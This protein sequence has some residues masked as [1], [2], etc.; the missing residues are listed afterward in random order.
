MRNMPLVVLL[1]F[2]ACV[3]TTESSTEYT[4]SSSTKTINIGG[5]TTE[6]GGLARIQVLT[7]LGVGSRAPGATWSTLATFTASTSGV[8][9]GGQSYYSWNGNVSGFS[10]A[11]WPSAGVARVRAQYR[12]GGT[13]TDGNTFDDL[14]C[15]TEH[16]G[17]DFASI[18]SA[19]ASHDSGH[20]HFVDGDPLTSSSRSYISLRETPTVSFGGA[21]VNDPALDYYAKVDPAS[22]RTTLADW[23]LLNGFDTFGGTLPGYDPVVA[24]TYFNKADLELGR[25]MFCLKRTGNAALACYVTNY[26]DPALFPNAGPQ[27]D[28]TAAL[29][30]A[31]GQTFNGLVAT[32]AM[33]YRPNDAANR[34]TFFAFD[35]AG[36]RV[37]KVKLDSQGAKNMPGACLSCHGGA[38]N[39]GTDSVVGAHFL[40]FDVDNF[41]YSTAAG[42]TLSSQQGAFRALN[43]LILGAGPTAAITELVTGWYGGN[44][45]ATGPAQDTEFMPAAWVDEDV[46]Y[47]EVIKPYCRGCHVALSDGPLPK[48]DFNSFAD[49]QGFQGVAL[50][51]VC[52]T[53]DMPHAEV[54]RRNFWGSPARGHLI[55]EFD[56]PTA[57]Q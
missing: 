15:L 28:E 10:N 18:A 16:L 40:P 33:E 39:T 13:W 46:M 8:S 25:R 6:S 34:V 45:T 12:I 42:F 43:N 1:L 55:G 27:D 20:L 31:V 30:A 14:S 49:L 3:V 19:C 2:G 37:T 54:T 57:C 50:T 52:E 41:S 21:V 22:L 9:N 11:T 32:V 23:Q 7:S 24:T 48:V 53:H 4:G 5:L 56:W 26:G 38:F 17:D 47:R 44:T 36:N 51:R 35:A 29:A